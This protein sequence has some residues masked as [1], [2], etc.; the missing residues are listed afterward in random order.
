MTDTLVQQ[1]MA[2]VVQL[3]DERNFTFEQIGEELNFSERTARRRYE[4]AL[5]N[6]AVDGLLADGTLGDFPRVPEIELKRIRNFI[7]E[8]KFEIERFKPLVAVGDA[9]VTSDFHIPL[10]DPGFIN[11]MI[12]A[13]RKHKIKKLIIGG[14]YFNMEDFS[15]Y[16]PPQPEAAIN[17][18]RRD[19]N[20]IMKTL[21]R[22]FD[23]IWFFWGN[24]DFRLTRKL[25]F[26]KSFEECME[27]ML[28]E[29]TE[30]EKKRVHISELDH[31]VY[32]PAG[33]DGLKFRVC[34]PKNYSDVPLAVG[35][36]LAVK[37]N[38]SIITAHSHHCAIGAAPN[39]V[40]IL[41]EA[42][43]FFD[44]ERTEYIQRTT[45]NHEW[46][47]GFTIFEEGLPRVVSPTLGNDRQ[48]RKEVKK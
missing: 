14:D 36:K 20:L 37:Y 48:Y 3:K 21:L 32:Y 40:D 46:V 6:N 34:H 30:E 29:L 12:N 9:I 19:G 2:Q 26:K 39:G 35:K 31:M 43:G 38:C 22:T 17:V 16:P 5:L 15:S 7:D 23:E 45:D 10:H 25:G 11:A 41:I 1:E 33:E 18:E 44:K 27:W 4:A 13:A 24:H 28:C 42:G 47:Q 8:D